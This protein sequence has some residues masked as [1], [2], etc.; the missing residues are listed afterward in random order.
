[1]GFSVNSFIQ[2][3]GIIDPDDILATG[4]IASNRMCLPAF[5][6]CDINFQYL[7][8]VPER[9]PEGC[10]SYIAFPLRYPLTLSGNLP[11]TEGWSPAIQASVF[12]NNPDYP[13]QILLNFVNHSADC[14]FDRWNTAVTP[15]SPAYIDCNDCFRFVMLHIV[16][17]CETQ[18][19]LW[20]R[21][22]GMTSCFVRV[23]DYV[24]QGCFYSLIEYKNNEDNENFFYDMNNWTQ[25][26][27][28]ASTYINSITLPMWLIQ[29][30]NN[31]E[32]KEYQY[33]DGTVVKLYERI[34]EEWQLETEW[35]SY[36]WHKCLKIALSSD[37]IKITNFNAVYFNPQF[38]GEVIGTG[39]YQIQ[40]DETN[41]SLA[42]GKGSVISK[43]NIYK[44]NLNCF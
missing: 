21:V 5:S 29:P 22:I 43:D 23:A 8:D 3:Q 15:E 26:G 32:S 13:G 25:N 11:I 40:W 17:D 16:R 1:M 27:P 6:M 28:G 35:M 39:D 4:C 18:A 19:V 31:S 33:S 34:T 42:K 12:F 38:N 44:R 9:I 41:V 7:Y 14:T 37:Y 24:S 30:Q 20:Q 2:Q 10:S 36:F